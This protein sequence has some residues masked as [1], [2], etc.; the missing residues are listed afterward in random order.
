MQ[1][2]ALRQPALPHAEYEGILAREFPK[3]LEYMKEHDRKISVRK[4]SASDDT[5]LF[6]SINVG[7]KFAGVLE[8][9]VMTY[10]NNAIKKRA[11]L[12]AEFFPELDTNSDVI[13][14]IKYDGSREDSYTCIPLDIYRH[15]KHNQ[16]CW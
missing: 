14:L 1:I 10:D 2:L 7:D 13:H 9:I 15:N 16:M 8:K 4:Y 11:S 6:F 5:H 3:F 12:H